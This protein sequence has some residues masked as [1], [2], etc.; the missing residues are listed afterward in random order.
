MKKKIIALLLAIIILPC[1]ALLTACKDEKEVVIGSLEYSNLVKESGANFYEEYFKTDMTLNYSA[2]TTTTWKQNV[3]WESQT[4]PGTKNN[5]DFDFNKTVDSAIKLEVYEYEDAADKEFISVKVSTSQTAVETGTKATADKL[6]TEKYTNTTVINN[7]Y[8]LINEG[9]T[10]KLY[11]DISVKENDVSKENRKVVYTY[12]N[13]SD[14]LKTFNSLQDDIDEGAI[15]WFY[16]TNLELFIV[17]GKYFKKGDNFGYSCNYATTNFEN[18][19][20]TRSEYY[21]KAVLDDEMPLSYNTKT[22]ITSDEM[23]A[24]IPLKNYKLHNESKITI[25]DDCAKITAPENF[26]A[27][28]QEPTISFDGFEY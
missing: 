27:T 15:N 9:T 10:Y 1:M 18:K 8:Y 28:T 6:S 3:E 23:V 24:I 20:Y 22:T 4:A 16:S 14:Y 5:E 7:T 26:T 21:V 12:N 25:S 13:V 19:H 11:A 17:G 2:K